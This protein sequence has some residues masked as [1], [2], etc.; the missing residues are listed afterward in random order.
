MGSTGSA[1][2]TGSGGSAFVD[3]QSSNTRHCPIGPKKKYV[4]IK[5]HY[6]ILNVAQSINLLCFWGL[7]GFGKKKK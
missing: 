1:G 2:S 6:F 3:L 4:W 5:C 7:R